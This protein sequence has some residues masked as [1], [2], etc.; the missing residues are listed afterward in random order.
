MDIDEFL[1]TESDVPKEG[2]RKALVEKQSSTF[3]TG[4][5]IE[6]QIE[7]VRELIQQKRFKEAEKIY[8]V[9]KEQYGTLAK[10]QEEER[11]SV[12]RQL[13][14]I[15]KELIEHLNKARTEMEQSAKIITDLLMKARQYMQQGNVDKANQLYLEV[16]RMFKQMPDAFSERKMMLENQ[17]LMFY[18]QLVNEF[19]RKKYDKLLGKRDEL[20][21]HMEIAGNYVRLGKTE[22]AKKE[23]QD[24][25]KLYSELPE[26]FLYEKTIIYRRIL[27]LYQMIEEGNV[28]S[29]LL[30]KQ[31]NDMHKINDMPKI[32]VPRLVRKDVPVTAAQGPAL[33]K[34][35]RKKGEQQKVEFSKGQSSVDIEQKKG[36]FSKKEVK[37]KEVEMDAPPLPM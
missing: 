1:E 20:V 28:R 30:E 15:N 34:E 35:E 27:A 2:G 14:G 4:R 16:R 9:I 19:N 10:R 25:N 11:R 33:S 21:R 32:Q 37:T 23:Y 29:P 26:G 3:V 8:Y 36:I 6:G 18:S 5:S 12:H 22:E 24:I 31:E 13:T 7:K 17:I